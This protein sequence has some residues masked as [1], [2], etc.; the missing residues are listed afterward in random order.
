MNPRS[1]IAHLTRV[2]SLYS[3]FYDNYHILTLTITHCIGVIWDIEEGIYAENFK[4]V[5]T[6]LSF[7]L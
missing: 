6:S 4:G 2:Y 1:S 5:Y 3:L 7:N